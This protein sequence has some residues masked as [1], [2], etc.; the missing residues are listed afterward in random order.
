M[1]EWHSLRPEKPVLPPVNIHGG[2]R[3]R[4]EGGARMLA[5]VNTPGREEPVELREVAE[6]SPAPDEAVIEVRSFSLNRGELAL[7]AGRPEGWRPGQDVS[8]VVTREAADGSGPREGSRVVGLMDQGGWAQR[9]AVPTSRLAVLP[10][11]VSFAQAAALPIAGLTALRALRLGGSLLGCRVLVTGAGGGVGRFAVEL[12]ATSGARVTGVAGSTERREGLREIGASEVVAETGDSTGTFDLILESAGGASLE[13]A[14]RLVGRGG[15][16][17]AFGNSSNENTSFNL[18]DFAG[19]FPE[20]ARLHAFIY[21]SGTESFAA[22]LERLV[23]LVAGGD[24]TPLIG[25]EESWRE[26]SQTAAALRERRVAGKAVFR[27]E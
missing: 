7:L 15:V 2:V 13:A 5:L 25:A 24:L 16:I 26:L 27:V 1:S 6:P 20:G 4:V 18:F 19:S 12:A 14:I 10:D 11:E 22:D 9:A 3:S 8:G 23:A 21:S 17:V